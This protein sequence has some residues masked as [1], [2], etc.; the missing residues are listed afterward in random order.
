MKNQKQ[1]LLFLFGIM[2]TLFLHAQDQSDVKFGKVNLADFNV[3]APAS[4]SGADAVI[5]SD[6]GKTFFTGN[7]K[8]FFSVVNYRFIRVKILNKNGLDHGNRTIYLQDNRDGYNERMIDLKGSTYN[9]ENGQIH[10]SKL[11]G[12][13]I[14]REK[15]S[16]YFDKMKVSMPAL[17]EGSVFDLTYTIKSNLYY[18]PFGWTFQ[19]EIPCLWSEYEVIIPA[20]YHY[21]I[22]STGNNH[23]D[24]ETKKQT[25]ENYAIT[26]DADAIA[27]NDMM[28][29]STSAIQSRWVMKNVPVMKEQP[30]MSTTENYLSRISFKLDYFQQDPEEPR[31]LEMKTWDTVSHG[32]FLRHDFGL[33]LNQDNTWMD[34]KLKTVTEGSANPDEETRRIYQFVRD[35][36]YCTDESDIY[37]ATSL[38]DVFKNRAGG[39]G[40]INLLLVAMLRHRN[41]D[42]VPAILSTRENG[43]VTKDLPLL[44]EY[45]YLICVA[46][47][48]GNMVKL[49]A[50]SHFNSYGS[51]PPKCYNWTARLMNDS[52]TTLIQLPPDSVTEKRITNVMFINDENGKY[53]GTLTTV[54]GTD[55]SFQTRDQVKSISEKEY[56]KELKKGYTDFEFSNEGFDSLNLPDFPLTLHYD[57]DL[58][59]TNGSDLIYFTPILTSGFSK[60]PFT[61]TERLFPVEMSDKMDYTYL[62]TMEI[63]NGFKVDDI[64]KSVRG[65]Y[66]ENEGMF[67]YLIQQNP[68]NIQMRVHLKFNKATFG[69]EEYTALRDFFALVVKKESEQIVFKKAK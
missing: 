59:N 25:M 30:Y 62:L 45:N 61:A 19:H 24:V 32:L 69:A 9:L 51:L 55:E 42:A 22:K 43:V 1:A 29:V 20:M 23:F 2:F 14:Y 34:A 4:D 48:L 44:Y 65:N 17:K 67:E 38:K 52:K 21:L 3:T 6:I 28:H 11:N 63:P 50:S 46:Y 35:S 64:P 5:I 41:I 18:K 31:Q 10:E 12:K 36:F 49:D 27:S 47:P 26:G 13:E 16:T 66:G 54:F 58:K 56:F 33:E 40:E 39:V 8:G 37:V 7:A 15:S 60:N 53:S 57:L 68:S